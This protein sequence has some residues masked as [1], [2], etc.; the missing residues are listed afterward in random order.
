MVSETDPKKEVHLCNCKNECPAHP[1]DRL[2][3][4]GDE[5]HH[6]DGTHHKIV[7]K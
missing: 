4:I 6:Q 5:C 2:M 3:H 1:K 7:K